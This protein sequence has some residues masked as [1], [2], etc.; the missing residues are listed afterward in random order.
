MYAGSQYVQLMLQSQPVD[1]PGNNLERQF[2]NDVMNNG[3]YRTQLIAT[4]VT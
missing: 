4:V 3:A 1:I 2:T